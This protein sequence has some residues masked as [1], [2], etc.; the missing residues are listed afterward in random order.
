MNVTVDQIHQE[1]QDVALHFNEDVIKFQSDSF[2][3]LQF[4]I[5]M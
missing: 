5:M 4:F 1:Q 3:I 2:K